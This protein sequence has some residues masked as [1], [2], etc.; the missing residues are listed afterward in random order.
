M[1]VALLFDHF[2]P[3]HLARLRGAAAAGLA[4]TGVEFYAH[5]RDYAWAPSDTAGLPVETVCKG[6]EMTKAEFRA[7]L[8]ALLDRLQ[9]E[10]VTIPGWS[11]RDALTALLWCLTR[12][13]PVIMMSESC[14]HDEVRTGWKEGVKRMILACCPAALAGG[15]LHQTYLEELG[16]KKEQISLGYDAVDNGYFTEGARH[17]REKA[18]RDRP[19]LFL[20]SARFIEKK[21]LPRLVAAYARYRQAVRA[22]GAASKEPWSLLLLGDGELRPALEAQVAEL[23]LQGCVSMPGFLQYEELPGFYARASAFIHASTTEQWGLVVNEAMASGLPVLV[24]N[25]CGSAADLVKEGINGFTFDPQDQEAMT[26]GMIRLASL[27]ADELIRFGQASR[28]IVAQW[29]PERFGRGLREAAE[30]AVK[31]THRAGWQ[32]RMLVKL[33]SSR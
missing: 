13:V 25:R 5:S 15:S 3:Y 10:V 14:A 29:G 18:G 7:A 32:N 22:G 12:Q 26:R 6:R 19:G 16:L 24:S 1:R 20:A 4:V 9:P 2:G 11:G 23:G 30:R 21:N 8:W 17:A 33:L 28:E 31:S 27:P